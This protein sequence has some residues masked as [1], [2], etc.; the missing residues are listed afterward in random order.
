MSGKAL[1]Q[2]E[3]TQL[4]RKMTLIMRES[5]IKTAYNMSTEEFF[6]DTLLVK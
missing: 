3:L 2:Y 5:A 1:K 4:N 6:T